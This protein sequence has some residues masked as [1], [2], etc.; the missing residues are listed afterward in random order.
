MQNN[1]IRNDQAMYIREIQTYL[2]RIAQ[3]DSDIPLI[4]VD[5]IYGPE[6][7]EAVTAFQEK[8][9]L[10]PTG[11]VNLETWNRIV[12]QYLKVIGENASPLPVSPFPSADYV[13]RPG[14]TGSLVGLVQVMLNSIA[15]SFSNI[16]EVA[17]S[18]N[19]DD[20]TRDA[21]RV[22]QEKAQLPPTGEVDR[23]TWDFLA[24]FYN[25]FK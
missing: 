6:T 21:V 13:L 4:V 14:D 19:Y 9:G 10:N 25:I 5:G 7:T 16:Q 24:R 12:A 1:D 11:T 15:Y 3:D 22:F 2:R 8:Y 18:G 20:E 17:V 23:T